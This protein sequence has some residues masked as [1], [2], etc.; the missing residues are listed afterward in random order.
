MVRSRKRITRKDLRQPDQFITLTSRFFRFFQEQ[1]TKIL[2][3]LALVIA[4]FLTLW[5]WDLYRKRQNR[6]AAQQYSQALAA[7]HKGQY[8]DALV[9]LERLKTYRSSTYGNLALL[10]RAHSHIALKRPSEAVP[11]LREFLAKER[12]NPYLRQLALLTLGYAYEMHG[13]C[14]EAADAFN[15]ARALAGPLQDDA[16]LGNA[17]CSAQSG[18]LNQALNSYRDYLSTYPASER[19]T[20]ISLRMQETEARMRGLSGRK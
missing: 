10:Y 12:K 11:I 4:L 2:L 7:Y 8:K 19:G 18:N 6:L 15:Q 1:R 5:G 9:Q 20:E 3:T 13:Q 17:R 14:Q 16:L